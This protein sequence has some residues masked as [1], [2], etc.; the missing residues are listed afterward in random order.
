MD[1][2][3]YVHWLLDGPDH[4]FVDAVTM[5]RTTVDAS[6]A[7]VLA[8]AD[9]AE[10]EYADGGFLL[11]TVD[12]GQRVAHSVSAM[13]AL[14][15]S[16]SVTQF[17]A[18]LV[19][20][21]NNIEGGPDGVQPTPP[22]LGLSQAATFLNL[23]G[24]IDPR[25]D[26]SDVPYEWDGTYMLSSRT[27]W[28]DPVLVASLGFQFDAEGIP[29][30]LRQ[31]SYY[32]NPVSIAQ[33]GLSY[34]SSYVRD[35]GNPADLAKAV[36]AAEKLLS[37]Q[38]E[39]GALRYP[40]DHYY[41]NTFLPAG[42]TSGMAQGQAMSLFARVWSQT[43]DARLLAAGDKALEFLMRPAELGGPLSNLGNID[44]AHRD[45]LVLE[46]VA[47]D[48]NYHVLNGFEFAAMG[49]G[50]WAKLAPIAGLSTQAAAELFFAESISSIEWIAAASDLN[51]ISGYDLAALVTNM[52]LPWAIPSYH[53]VHV[54]ATSTLAAM[55]GSAALNAIVDRWVA[56]V[57]PVYLSTEADGTELYQVPAGI[58]TQKDGFW[59]YRDNPDWSPNL[60]LPSDVTGVPTGATQ[61]D[62]LATTSGNDVYFVDH[63]GDTISESA[64]GGYDL[65]VT[66]LTQYEL[67]TSVE[68]LAAYGVALFVD[69]NF[70]GND[71]HN[72]ITGNLGS[73]TLDGGTGED[74]MWGYRGDDTYV[75]DTA[76]DT[77]YELA[78]DGF[79]V[80]RARASYTLIRGQY[81]EVLEAFDRFGTDA[82][83]LIGNE[84][85]Q[86]IRGNE[87]ANAFNGRGGQDTFAGYGGNDTYA[88]DDLTDVVIEIA[89]QGVDRVVVYDRWI[90]TA[91]QSIEQIVTP[92]VTQTIAIAM[93]GNELAQTLTGN[94][95]ANAIDG[96]GGN[97][98][99]SGNDGSDTLDGGTGIDSLTGGLGDD[100]YFVDE[101]GDV[102]S[103]ALDGGNLDVV[104]TTVNY[105]LTTTSYVERLEAFDAA[106]T[107]PL[108]LSGNNAA[109]AITGNAGDNVLNGG[110]GADT[111]FGLNG[112]DTLSGGAGA[113][114]LYGGAGDDTYHVDTSADLVFEIVGAG[115]DTIYASLSFALSA[116]SEIESLRAVMPTDTA[117]INLVGNTLAN[118]IIGNAGSN[119]LQGG[120]GN[121]TLFGLGGNDV[122]NGGAGTDRLT[123]GGGNDIYHLDAAGDLI[124]E[125]AG[126]GYDTLFTTVSYV[127][128]TVT[129]VEVL[130]TTSPSGTAAINLTGNGIANILIGN[131]AGNRLLSL[132]GNDTIDGGDGN[133][134]IDGGSGADR[135]VGGAGHD[136]YYVDQ[137]SDVVMETAGGGVDTIYT[138]VS[139]TLT[140]LQDVEFLRAADPFATNLSLTGNALAN[141]L[142]GSGGTNTL[143][144]GDGDDALS[145]LGGADTLSG[146]AG[147]D[148]LIGGLGMDVLTGGLGGDRFYFDAALGASNVD[149][150]S[151]F[152]VGEDTIWLSRAVFD[153]IAATGVLTAD[154]FA[155]GSAATSAS[156]RIIYSTATGALSYDADGSGIGAATQFATLSPDLLITGSL[157]FVY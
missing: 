79:D 145:G 150:V 11:V 73:N 95:G 96:G 133:D 6:V 68:N 147:V 112:A 117:A 30:Y 17:D 101:V 154:A 70:V 134:T 138:S 42:W 14:V 54:F 139:L 104:R 114:W 35:G 98:T 108:Y 83:T 56:D 60:P 110:G 47:T 69:L 137:T 23:H 149:I 45:Q 84:F 74:R 102:V 43:N 71:L 3:G 116:Q 29:M 143:T 85:A 31:G 58:L 51:G 33:F 63:E 157:I 135:L 122:L 76:R 59:A 103:E 21:A 34:Y 90:A 106:G 7:A 109:N 87:G 39:D 89:G 62:V 92:N 148:R 20:A 131:A 115:V 75:V 128:P 53:R 52:P 44:A 55:S 64:V 107:A 2:F 151:D 46:E 67:P 100:T 132:A 124:V 13:G 65:V 36:Q 99:L 12:A 123:G 24:T 27:A 66:S 136:V 50:D 93:T 88:V 120:A 37:L 80:V 38:S 146:G 126:E 77:T 16:T 5:A 8:A 153:G 113:D 57:T 4:V 32:Y 142:V 1:R 86:E 10:V 48:P 140:A 25:F 18:A 94:A 152:A 82:L 91:G 22:F 97:D 119:A 127:L 125:L 155:L 26:L 129:D 111:L 61:A 72:D 81:L 141:T 49:V 9:S 130:R 19:N 15:S 144:G 156:Q 121:D 118:T 78:G 40:F 28:A 41:H 105:V